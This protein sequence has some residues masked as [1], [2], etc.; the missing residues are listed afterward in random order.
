[1]D[2]KLSWKK[3]LGLA[4]TVSVVV[5]VVMGLVYIQQATKQNTLKLTLAQTQNKMAA[6]GAQTY[7]AQQADI[8]A[9]LVSLS[10][11]IAGIKQ[12]FKPDVASI[13]VVDAVTALAEAHDLTLVEVNSTGKSTKALGTVPTTVQTITLTVDGTIANFYD[14]VTALGTMYPTGVITTTKV[15]VGVVAP[16]TA[17][18]TLNVYSYEGD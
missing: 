14:F 4:T 10:Q 2:T 8:Q 6:S 16:W 15:E 3:G 1:M 11:D 5:L 17:S 7:V 13:P 9:K 12:S 18:L